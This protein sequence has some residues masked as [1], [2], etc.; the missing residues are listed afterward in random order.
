MTID[1]SVIIWLFKV[2][3]TNL[4]FCDKFGMLEILFVDGFEVV[5]FYSVF[6]E[7]LWVGVKWVGFS[8]SLIMV[9]SFYVK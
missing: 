5:G 8:G 3:Y 4:T 2:D 1:C 7:R 9:L 6:K